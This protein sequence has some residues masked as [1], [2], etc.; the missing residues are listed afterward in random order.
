ME[1][2]KGQLLPGTLN[3]IILKTLETLGPL[4]GYGVARP[5]EQIS[6]DRFQLNQGTMYPALLHLEQMEWTSKCG[7]RRTIENFFNQLRE[8]IA[9]L[10]GVEQASISKNTPLSGVSVGYRTMRI[11]GQFTP[12]DMAG[13]G[14]ELH[15]ISPE[16]LSTFRIPLTRGRNFTYDDRT[17]GKR[18]TI[19]SEN[20]ARRFWPGADPLGALISLG[21]DEQWI[22]VVGVIAD[23][24][25]WRLEDSPAVSVY[26]PNTQHT[27]RLPNAL[28]VRGTI[29]KAAL[30]MA[31][32]REIAALDRN[33]LVATIRTIDE[34]F[35]EATAQVR[36]GAILLVLFAVLA[37][38]ISQIGVY[39]VISYAVSARTQ[40]IGIRM[41]LGAQRRDVLKLVVR[42]GM[43]LAMSG[44]AIGLMAAFGL[45]RLM[46]AMLFGI[47]ETDTTTFAII[48]L[49]LA[50]VAMLACYL[51]ARRATKVDPLIVLRSE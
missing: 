24:P 7:V 1:Q 30:A 31:V 33:I 50:G 19:I 15:N 6:A 42:Q 43:I 10:P 16:Y 51:P 17:G 39:G 40:E 25:Y 46:K 44:L 12:S 27:G 41:A 22:E 36:Y 38:V 11:Q 37:L 32:R 47:S 29:E 23:V 34:K 3:L 48:S 9:V 20:T 14:V 21:S 8:R 13:R 49:L 26:V 5:I 35:T 18:V 45:T 2:N 28:S 4:H